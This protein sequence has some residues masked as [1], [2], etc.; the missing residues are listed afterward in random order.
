MVCV[1]EVKMAV[2]MMVMARELE[3]VEVMAMEL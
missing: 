2:T 1:K 3:V